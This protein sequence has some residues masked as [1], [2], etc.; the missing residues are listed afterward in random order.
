MSDFPASDFTKPA[1]RASAQTIRGQ[2]PMA[3]ISR[4]IRL[5]ITE[6]PFFSTAERVLI[7]HPF[8]SEVDLLPL[9]L[10]YPEKL[11]YLP[12]TGPNTSMTFHPYHPHQDLQS[13]E[14]GIQEPHRHNEEATITPLDL[15]PVDLMVLPGLIFDRAGYRIGYGKGYFDRFLGQARLSQRHCVTVGAVPEALLV[16]TVPRDE[17]DLPVE[18][19]VTERDVFKAISG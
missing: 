9:A 10:R 6:L 1:L 15:R 17:W 3:E 4:E 8:R 14:F 11:W 16:D 5:R 7:Y 13:G 19:L 18:W 2:L 12:S